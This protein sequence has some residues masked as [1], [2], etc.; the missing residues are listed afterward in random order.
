MTIGKTL[1]FAQTTLAKLRRNRKN[2]FV[3]RSSLSKERQ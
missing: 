1:A 3:S 2:P